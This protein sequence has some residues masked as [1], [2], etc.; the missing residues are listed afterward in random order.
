MSEGQG[1]CGNILH[2]EQK[3]PFFKE[4]RGIRGQEAG[5]AGPRKP[6]IHLG[7]AVQVIYSLVSHNLAL[8]DQAYMG[9]KS[10]TDFTFQQGVVGAGQKH[11]INFRI[12][13]KQG[14]HLFLDK[15]AGTFGTHLAVFY[16]GNPHGASMLGHLQFRE[17]MTDFYLVTVGRNRACGGEDSDMPRVAEI[18]DLFGG[19]PDDSQHPLIREFCG[20]HLL[21]NAPE[22]A[23]RCRVTGE[24][25]HGAASAEKFPHA[26]EGVAKDGLETPAAVRRTGIVSQVQ[27]IIVRQG[28]LQVPQNGE[29]AESGIKD[30]YHR[31]ASMR[32]RTRGINSFLGSLLP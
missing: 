9:R 2:S 16:Q 10:R 6:G 23:G 14:V 29:T 30:A 8:N 7:V 24:D 25:Y 11:R 28:R 12:L 17:E 26:L 27:K 20:Q 15:E 21:L 22:G 1:F 18:A 4:F 31:A 5:S 32:E 3:S 13:L 19:G